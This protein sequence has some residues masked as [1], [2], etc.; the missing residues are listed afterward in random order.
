MNRHFRRTIE[1]LKR[2]KPKL[3]KEP[4][5]AKTDLRLLE[6]QKSITSTQEA[7]LKYR[8]SKV[9]KES[10]LYRKIDIIL[11]KPRTVSLREIHDKLFTPMNKI[12]KVADNDKV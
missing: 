3:R 11:A 6:K 10:S 4:Q 2:K 12:D 5:I 7:Y 1:A 8:Q 9:G